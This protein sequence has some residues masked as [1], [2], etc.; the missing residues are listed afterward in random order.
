MKNAV[1]L[2]S[3]NGIAYNTTAET[4]TGVMPVGNA[5]INHGA[6]TQIQTISNWLTHS[7]QGIAVDGNAILLT[8]LILSQS[9]D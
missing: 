4:L 7:C 3:F 2:R 6:H 1:G 5:T 8:V 9:S